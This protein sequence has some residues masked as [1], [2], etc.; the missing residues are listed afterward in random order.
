M[1]AGDCCVWS[2]AVSQDGKW[3]VS[4]TTDGQVTVWDAK[5]HEKVNEFRG[6]DRIVSA[7]DVTPDA[8]KIVTG[9]YDTTVCVWSLATGERLLGPFRIENTRWGPSPVHAVKLSP[10]GRLFA[11]ATNF[12]ETVRIYDIQDGRLVDFPVQV[13]FSV[14]QSLAWVGDNQHLFALSSEG[15]I[16]HL[17]MSTESTLHQWS[18]C[19][20]GSQRRPS[21]IALA[22]N[23]AFIA[24]SNYTSVSFWDPTTHKQFGP[25]IH[26]PNRVDCMAISANFDLMMGG[27]TKL[28]LWNLREI[29]PSPYVD[30]DGVSVLASKLNASDC[31]TLYSKF[32]TRRLK[33][34]QRKRSGF[35]VHRANNQVCLLWCLLLL[36]I[37]KFISREN[38][39][40]REIRPRTPFPTCRLPKLCQP[41]GR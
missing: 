10:S 31:D 27:G 18:V 28:I 25:V 13:S 1:I 36:L 15:D 7:V 20:K 26:H 8:T 11:T 19:S 2:V 41:N 34:L 24:A 35:L 38:S 16:H 12:Q 21:C 9:S 23:G 22:S 29:L 33:H 40:P 32:S 5:S 39:Q 6:H 37:P 30:C 14:N 4:G 3:I 17:D